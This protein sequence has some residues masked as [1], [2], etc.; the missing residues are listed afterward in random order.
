MLIYFSIFLYFCKHFTLTVPVTTVK[1][2]R[3]SPP[4]ILACYSFGAYG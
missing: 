4:L 3:V 1:T 2:D